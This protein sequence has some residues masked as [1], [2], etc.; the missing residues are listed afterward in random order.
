MGFIVTILLAEGAWTLAGGLGGQDA[1]SRLVG[2]IGSTGLTHVLP[3]DSLG[4]NRVNLEVLE[5]HVRKEAS[6]HGAIRFREL[7]HEKEGLHISLQLE[8]T[9]DDALH[10]CR[11]LV[12]LLLDGFRVV[13]AGLKHDLLKSRPSQNSIRLAI[14]SLEVVPELLGV[15]L[16]PRRSLLIPHNLAADVWRNAIENRT[17]STTV[18]DLPCRIVS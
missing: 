10:S 3:G 6:D 1:L 11:E 2:R 7:R 9:V 4:E 14:P 18:L 15:T 5:V 8:S 12:C 16:A 17:S 13:E